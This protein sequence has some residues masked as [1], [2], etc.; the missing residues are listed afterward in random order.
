M[1]KK[2][3]I[4]FVSHEA[5]TTGAPLLLL[6]LHKWLQ[7]NM[8][9]E[10]IFLL[11]T[12][13]SIKSKFESQAKTFLW[14]LLRPQDGQH[15]RF[16]FNRL[17]KIVIALL[18]KQEQFD[19]VYFNSVSSC[20]IIPTLKKFNI[21]KKYLLHVHELDNAID[22]YHAKE[23]SR[24]IPL[25]DHFIAVSQ[26]V[27]DSLVN[28]WEI[29]S[30]KVSLI[31]PCVFE[32]EG[33]LQNEDIRHKFN[34]TNDT[35]I[36]GSCGEMGDRKGTD[37][38]IN[39]AKLFFRQNPHANAVFLWLGN[40]RQE[41]KVAEYRNILQENGLTE[42]VIFAGA[43]Q[44]AGDYFK[45]FDLFLLTSREDPFP[46][47]ALE[48]GMAGNPI[49]CFDQNNGC[50]EYVNDTCGK[51]VPYENTNE[52]TEA[53]TSFFSNKNKLV[54][55]QNEIKKAVKKYTA[56]TTGNAIKDVLYSL[57]KG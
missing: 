53:I 39:T 51:V 24:A 33:F 36:V 27:R 50:T 35:F 15:I 17:R 16:L 19:I 8:D 44:N 32:R 14:D 7:N 30:D 2:Q 49:I 34:I 45:E 13:G 52:M 47:V 11:K 18:L 57:L 26:N 48:N 42:K 56:N 43:H 38:F 29:P 10:S 5:S 31:H 46:L 4:L 12:A 25:I 37:L 9:I 40:C 55:A 20:D 23:L 21:G 41:S 1:S 6:G 28:C 22:R 54:N 3:K